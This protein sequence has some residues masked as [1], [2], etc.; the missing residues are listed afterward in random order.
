MTVTLYRTEPAHNMARFYHLDLQTD[1][2]G[3]CCVVWQ[4]SNIRVPA[5]L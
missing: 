3:A 4:N 1:L 5:R 2:C